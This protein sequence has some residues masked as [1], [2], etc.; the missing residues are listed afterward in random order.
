[1]N[2]TELHRAFSK[3]F[4]TAIMLTNLELEQQTSTHTSDLGE[5]GCFVT[6]TPFHLGAKVRI[7]IFMQDR[8]FVGLSR[9][10]AS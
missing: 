3:P 1:L 7:M 2:P 6:S 5:H 9:V 8:K 10:M 4:V